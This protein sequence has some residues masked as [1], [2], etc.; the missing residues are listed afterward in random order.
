MLL[1]DMFRDGREVVTAEPNDTIAQAT[2]KMKEA[3]VGAVIVTEGGKVVGILTDRD[4]ALATV[5]GEASPE[6]PVS[7][8]MTKDVKTIWA[9]QGVFNATQYLAGQKVRRLP[10]IDRKNRLV[11]LVTADDLFALLSR[12]LFN[13]SQALEPALHE[14]V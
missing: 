8:V 6:S 13:V 9:D 14:T 5:L 10:V 12:E 2:R 3:D 11:G 4:V 7:E 1:Q